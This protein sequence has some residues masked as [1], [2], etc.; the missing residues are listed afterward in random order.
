MAVYQNV[1]T[2]FACTVNIANIAVNS[3]KFPIIIGIFK[4]YYNR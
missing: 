3:L 1:N 4:T 2:I